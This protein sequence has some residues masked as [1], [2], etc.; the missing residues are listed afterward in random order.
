MLFI[1]RFWKMCKVF[2]AFEVVLK[3]LNSTVLWLIVSFYRGSLWNEDRNDLKAGSCFVQQMLSFRFQFHSNFIISSHSGKLMFG[4]G[5]AGRGNG[6]QLVTL[7]HSTP[8]LLPS[9]I[10]SRHNWHPDCHSTAISQSFVLLTSKKFFSWSKRRLKNNMHC[11]LCN[12]SVFLWQ[13]WQILLRALGYKTCSMIKGVWIS[14]F[15]M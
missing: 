4:L 6:R 14:G 12:R 9:P 7:I 2:E 1:H 10:N 13:T 11:I 15:N 5:R 8:P 3:H